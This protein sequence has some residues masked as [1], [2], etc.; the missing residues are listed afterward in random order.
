[1][2]EV[3]AILLIKWYGRLVSMWRLSLLIWNEDDI[4]SIPTAQDCQKDQIKLGKTVYETY[5]LP[6]VCSSLFP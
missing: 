2:L 1:M 5:K 4:V 3:E 6:D